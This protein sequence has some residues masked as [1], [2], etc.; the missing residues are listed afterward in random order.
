MKNKIA[1]QL[2]TVTTLS[3][4]VTSTMPMVA[5]AEESNAQVA[6]EGQEETSSEI[7]SENSNMKVTEV[8]NEDGSTT[9]IYEYTEEVDAKDLADAISKAEEKKKEQE[10]IKSEIKAG[11][12]Q[13]DY[14]VD[15]VDKSTEE[16]AKDQ[17][18][19]KSDA[20][21]AAEKVNGT[22]TEVEGET[23]EGQTSS[24]D[25]FKSEEEAKEWADEEAKRLEES[26][27]SDTS[28]KVTTKT[29]ISKVEGTGTT[30]EETKEFET[31]EFDTR[32]EAEEYAKSFN[33]SDYTITPVNGR[34][35]YQKK[36]VTAT[37]DD[38]NVIHFDSEEEAN[39]YIEDNKVEG[40]FL[41][42]VDIID[43]DTDTVIES[44]VITATTYEDFKKK[45]EELY[46][47]A[48]ADEN[49]TIEEKMEDVLKNY[50]TSINF[51]KLTEE[52]KKELMQKMQEDAKDQDYTYVHLDLQ[53]A[54]K[55]NVYDE[56]GN[57][58]QVKCNIKDNKDLK[59]YVFAEIDG[60]MQ[61]IPMEAYITRD[62]QGYWEI[63]SKDK[64][65]NL[66]KSF[67]LIQGT[68]QYSDNG[69]TKEVP[70]STTGYLNN[71][72]NTCSQK[73]GNTGSNKPGHWERKS[74][75]YDIVLDSFN[76]DSEGKVTVESSV[77]KV[78]TITVTK[79]STKYVV[80]YQVDDPETGEYKE[81]YQ[82]SGTYVE[83][84]EIPPE[85]MAEITSQLTNI[86][87]DVDYTKINQDFKVIVNG[88]GKVT[89][90]PVTPTPEPKPEPKPNP[91]PGPETNDNS[92]TEA[93]NVSVK[94]PETVIIAEVPVPLGEQP[95]TP[96]ATPEQ[97]I[98][99]PKTGDD[100]LA[101]TATAGAATMA[102]FLALLLNA[103]P[104][105]KKKRDDE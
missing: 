23:T 40:G 4:L 70:F 72:Y 13:Y 86:L 74:G 77:T 22:I 103:I 82:V 16:K 9:T 32:E 66:K 18:D 11:G 90:V 78:Y 34:W 79:K 14:N 76:M 50:K 59:V 28:E 37:D 36:E 20:E 1:R 7:S 105:A 99:T 71:D 55:I 64:R 87:Y 25:G 96:A 104:F 41:D 91:E 57:A 27:V 61:Q 84:T 94:E 60:K 26:Q 73:P 45:V 101:K 75:G 43:T 39:K 44:V 93:V 30:V 81:E 29:E 67:V 65:M 5:F 38:G 49:V 24:K 17:Y 88:E 95:E 6:S 21:K 46:A 97:E 10:Q 69:V 92:T 83:E 63:R 3:V 51:E 102:G 33:K 12:G 8:K 89:V 52:Q 19:S 47:Q 15:I 56:N 100:N 85:Y 62:P 35:V 98:T 54:A 58:T 31:K 48:A 80:K 53:T 2:I 42:K 68:L